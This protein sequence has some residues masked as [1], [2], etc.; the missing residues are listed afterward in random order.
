MRNTVSSPFYLRIAKDIAYRIS[1]GE[2]AE[3]QRIYGRSAMASEYKTSPETI[4]RSMRLLADM[5]VVDVK[6]QSGATVLSRDNAA[7]YIRNFEDTSSVVVIMRQLQE[8]KSQYDELNRKTISAVEEIIHSRYS[9]SAANE[10][11]PNYEIS[12]PP[13]SK[14]IGKSIGNLKF[15][16]LTGATIIAIRRGKNVILSPGPYAELYDGDAIIFVGSPDA[17]DAV[18]R[19][20]SEEEQH[21]TI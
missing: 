15:W 14:L 2:F 20:V 4:R 3:G 18:G 17:A 11:L 21:D 7:R 19:L 9:F 5:K 8:L 13:S 1:C 12:V 16:Q 6:P 10:P